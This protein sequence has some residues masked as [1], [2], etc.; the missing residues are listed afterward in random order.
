[1]KL[2]GQAARLFVESLKL[3]E[4]LKDQD[5][6]A[7]CL[8]GIAAVE[9]VAGPAECSMQLF[10]A[11]ES[12]REELHVPIDIA[13]QPEHEYYVDCAR[14]RLEPEAAEN[15]W[16]AGLGLDHETAV[17]VATDAAATAMAQNAEFHDA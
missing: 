3:A 16:N 8:E 14:N 5:C 15:A 6:V 4:E 1:R 13:D 9:S 11:A 17:R 7:A 12:L 2:A 10:G